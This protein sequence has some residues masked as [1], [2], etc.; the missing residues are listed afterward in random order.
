MSEWQT[1]ETAPRDGTWILGWC[2]RSDIQDTVQVWHWYEFHEGWYWQN[3]ADSNDLDDQ[4]TYW[5]PLPAPPG[6]A[7]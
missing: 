4:P 2:K 5:M 7:G 1:M 6:E 3:A